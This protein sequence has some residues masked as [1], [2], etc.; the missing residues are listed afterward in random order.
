MKNRYRIYKTNKQQYFEV[1]FQ[2]IE[3]T[4]HWNFLDYYDKYDNAVIAIKKALEHQSIYEI[5]EVCEVFEP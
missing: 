1:Q 5:V 2:N 4:S 3:D